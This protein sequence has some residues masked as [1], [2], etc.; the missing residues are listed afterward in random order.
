SKYVKKEWTFALAN[1]K[2]IIPVLLDSTQL[3]RKLKKFQWI[4]FR[5]KAHLD[6]LQGAAG[7]Q[8]YGRPQRI[9]PFAFVAILGAAI[10]FLSLYSKAFEGVLPL[11][12]LVGLIALACVALA[13]FCF[14]IM[15]RKR[16]YSIEE[17]N[18]S[19][20]NLAEQFRQAAIQAAIPL[21]AEELKE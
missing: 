8:A 1:D 3:P 15:R 14:R 21:M 9:A 6:P 13:V 18:A 11:N 4:D 20:S 12:I 2:S 16:V 7:A 10:L 5:G 19:R 17:P